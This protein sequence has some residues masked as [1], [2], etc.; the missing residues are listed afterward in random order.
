MRAPLLLLPLAAFAATY[1]TTTEDFPNPERG[2]FIQNSYNPERGSTG[3]LNPATLR[4]A[5][6]NGM[7]L[8]RRNWMFFEF[9][10]RPLSPAML[11]HVRAD[12]AAAR[13]AGIK[14]I[15][16]FEYNLGPVGEPDAPLP[17]VLQHLDQLAPVLRENSDVIA[18]MEAGFIGTWGEWHHSTNNLLD[19]TRDIVEKFLSVLPTDRMIAL[20]YPRLKTNL[21]GLD[22]LTSA[23]AFTG[24]PKARIG[25]HNDCFLASQ[26]DWGTWSK[27]VVAE[28]AF[29]H[30]ENLYLPQGGETCNAKEDAQLYIGCEN[31]LRE[32]AY[33]RFNSLNS[34]YQQ[35]VLDG[36]TR[37]GCMDEIKRRL[38]YRFHLVESAVQ[39]EGGTLHLAVTIRNDGFG[40]LF[41]PRPVYLVLRD[42]ATGKTESTLVPTDPRR[43][44]PG[45]TTVLHVTRAAPSGGYDI[46]L[47]LPDAAESLRGRPEYAVRFANPE[48]W[49]PASG[50]NR[51]SRSPR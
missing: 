40:N 12:F 36:W 43:W 42:R 38:G 10:D 21:Y 32:L 31:A 22:A 2:F 23:E 34:L 15:G 49:E 16:R 25:G 20:R 33:Q 13:S 3:P 30:Q 9:R 39:V 11:D 47:H 8:L 19:H 5:R 6:D 37:G 18:Y 48:V 24:T 41:N 4:R 51:L 50:M 46:L 7:T 29:Y 44:M 27:N 35:E 26:T 14:I 17:V 45:E 28:K 1:P